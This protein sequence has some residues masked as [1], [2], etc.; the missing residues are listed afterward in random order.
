MR[1]FCT[2]VFACPK[3]RR[4]TLLDGSSLGRG[5]AAVAVLVVDAFAAVSAAQGP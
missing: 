2:L 3:A 5:A 1:T 4:M